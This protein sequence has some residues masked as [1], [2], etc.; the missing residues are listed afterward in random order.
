MENKNIT[1]EEIIK[2]VEE[3]P[4]DYIIN[5]DFEEQEPLKCPITDELVVH[6]YYEGNTECKNQNWASNLTLSNGEVVGILTVDGVS[7]WDDKD[8]L[9]LV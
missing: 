3:N 2:K 6:K 7:N 5:K 4:E 8:F 9:I 1:M